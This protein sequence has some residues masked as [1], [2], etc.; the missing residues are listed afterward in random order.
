MLYILMFGH[1]VGDF[2]CQTN[3]MAMGKS[4]RMVPLVAHVAVYTLVVT[5][6]ACVAVDWEG[7]E[8]WSMSILLF[9]ASNAGLHLVVDFITSRISSY[10]YSKKDMHKFFITIGF[11]QYLHFV[12]IVLTA[13]HFL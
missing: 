11:D 13:R 8:W 3:W 4:K 12:S 9:A 2:I 5:L 6:F 10:F 7:K 1:W